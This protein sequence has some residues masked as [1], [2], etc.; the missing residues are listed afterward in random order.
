MTRIAS[1]AFF[2]LFVLTPLSGQWDYNGGAVLFPTRNAAFISD[3]DNPAYG[4]RTRRSWISMSGHDRYLLPELALQSFRT[5][6]PTGTGS[7]HAIGVHSGN[8]YLRKAR[9]S[10]GYARLF[11]ERTEA[12]V[13][14][15][16]AMVW[17]G[18]G[19]GQRLYWKGS[20]GIRSSFTDDLRWELWIRDPHSA[21]REAPH[22]SLLSP[23]IAA[24]VGKRW[25]GKN[26]WTLEFSKALGSPLRIRSKGRIGLHPDW[27]FITG[28][29]AFPLRPEI[30]WSWS[31]E[32]TF[33]R[34]SSSWDP[35][36]GFTPSCLIAYRVTK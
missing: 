22:R 24:A 3:P 10:L 34:M 13:R 26:S 14:L 30:G 21:L 31:R 7:F 8:R 25:P 32:R 9:F 20:F 5:V 19:H 29:R 11:G 23:T 1:T 4:A 35:V 12:G 18:E 6:I 2:I 16:P 15:G 27:E 36:L 28:L 33:I 17:I